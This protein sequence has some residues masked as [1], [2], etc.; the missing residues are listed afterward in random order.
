M[1]KLLQNHPNYRQFPVNGYDMVWPLISGRK[2][3][4]LSQKHPPLLVRFYKFLLW[5]AIFWLLI[6]FGLMDESARKD[7]AT[8]YFGIGF[9]IYCALL[10]GLTYWFIDAPVREQKRYYRETAAKPLTLEQSLA[11]RL[12]ITQAYDYGFW[13]ETIEHYPLAVLVNDTSTYKWLPFAPRESGTESLLNDWGIETREEFYSYVERLLAG[14]HTPHF[15]YELKQSGNEHLIKLLAALTEIPVELIVQS[16]QSING[17]PPN[18]IWGFDLWRIIPM[19]HNA[20]SAGFITR[21]EGWDI[22]LNVADISHEIFESFE[23][24]NRSYRIGHA[25][26]SQNKALTEK[27]LEDYL[28]YKQHCDWPIAKLAWPAPKG[29]ELTSAMRTGVFE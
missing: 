1:S 23:A 20:L 12:D 28:Q 7:L 10:G 27:R 8:P 11:L 13:T 2:W 21:D 25:F 15:A 5:L 3:D 19:V 14:M 4:K 16:N 6:L 17:R 9:V 26:W 29:I 22:L 18:L 24:F